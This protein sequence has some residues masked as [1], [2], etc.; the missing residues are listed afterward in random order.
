MQKII[1]RFNFITCPLII[2]LI[3]LGLPLP[4]FAQEDITITTYYPSPSGSFNNL[5]VTQNLNFENGVYIRVRQ[6]G[7]SFVNVAQFF[8]D[9][10]DFLVPINPG[11]VT[12]FGDITADNI[13]ADNITATSSLN[14]GTTNVG[15]ALNRR[16]LWDWAIYANQQ[17]Q[18]TAI[19]G[20]CGAVGLLDPVR[21]IMAAGVLA[22]FLLI[23]TL[24]APFPN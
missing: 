2:S 14:A 9:H 18:S 19:G 16:L 17:G 22:A 12:D 20:I 23:I 21:Q 6:P 15:Q 5:T 10:I 13:T 8:W 4:L 11:R 7:G 24:P 1:T 3:L